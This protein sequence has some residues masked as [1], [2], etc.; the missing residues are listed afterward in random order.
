MGVFNSNI[1]EPFGLR[2]V[3]VVKYLHL[4][5]KI[6]RCFFCRIT[7]Q[8][9]GGFLLVVLTTVERQIYQERR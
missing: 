6:L 8:P 9:A 2:L 7:T 5:K 1:L 4:N 3:E